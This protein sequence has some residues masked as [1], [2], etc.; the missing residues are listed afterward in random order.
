MCLTLHTNLQRGIKLREIKVVK[1]K[2]KNNNN[3]KKRLHKSA[4]YAA[5]MQ[6]SSKPDSYL[7][8]TFSV[9]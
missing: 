1:L 2:K 7:R 8:V 4:V 6:L 9:R 3:N 5:K